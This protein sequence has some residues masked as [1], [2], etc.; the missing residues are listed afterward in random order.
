MNLRNL[1]YKGFSTLAVQ[2]IRQFELST[3]CPREAQSEK[4]RSIISKNQSTRFGREH[5]F[6]NITTWE[7]FD[8]S[9]PVRTYDAF[10][11][12]L[13]RLTAGDTEVLTVQTPFMFATTSGTTGEP[14]YIP[15]TNDYMEEF[16]YASVVSG[17]HLLQHCP[18]ITG[19]TALS[20]TSAAEEGR[21]PS[22]IPYGAMSGALFQRES[23]LMRKFIS[24]IP[25]EAYLIKDYESR[26]YTILRL[27][28]CQPVSFF[29]TLNPSTIQLLCRRLSRYAN[30]LVSDIAHGTTTPPQALDR[31]TANAISHLTKPKIV[32]ARE[33]ERLIVE[34]RFTPEYIW[35]MLAVVSCWTKAAAAFYLADFP[36]YFGSVPVRDITYGASEGRGTVFL[37]PD[38]QALALNSHFYEFI[39]EAEIDS[40]S[41]TVLLADQLVKGE[42]YYILFTT[43]G[44][45][46]RYNI[47]DVVKVTGF[48]NATPLLEFQYK[49]GNISSFTGEKIT[50]LQVTESMS[51]LLAE[52]PH[53]IR[54]F[55]LMPEFRPEPHYQLW[56]EPDGADFSSSV[57]RDL[58]DRFDRTL[59]SLNIEYQ[60]KRDS[61]RLGPVV[62]YLISTGTYE[63]LR[64]HLVSLG[65]P[66]SQIKI[67]HLNPK[68]DLKCYIEQRLAST[69]AARLS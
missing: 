26:Y 33:L 35:P 50:E 39:P 19:G 59:G 31:G 25:Y 17:Y 3:H 12:Y 9:V 65:T 2:K 36:K 27:A 56:V 43:S 13:D 7:D 22:G 51:K 15:I 47:N 58:A 10:K 44:G 53:A 57:L 23:F 54:F 20:M 64:R 69:T 68:E 37:S 8:K 67:S 1:L 60:L 18:G 21:T 32:R 6:A 30:D 42:N 5:G 52:Y 49:G 38:K 66:D 48:H 29:Y 46:Y 11:P 28:L 14:K 62:P 16:R 45:L 24:P 41:P 4:L 55:V 63:S 40:T 61:Q 34:N